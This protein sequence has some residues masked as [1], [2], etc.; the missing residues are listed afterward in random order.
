MSV[1]V[2]TLRN[3]QIHPKVFALVLAC[4][5]MTMLFAA[6]TSAYVV[7]Q[8]AGNWLEFPLPTYFYISTGIIVLSLSLIHI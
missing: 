4:V 3:N 7:R 5:S 8:A 6:F 2:E 1:A